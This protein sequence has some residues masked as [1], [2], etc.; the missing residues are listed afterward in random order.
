MIL[1]WLAKN[2]SGPLESS[3]RLV[4][5]W[6]HLWLEKSTNWHERLFSQNDQGG[7]TQNDVEPI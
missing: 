3:G 4:F 6:S 2:W 1:L 5:V 7:K